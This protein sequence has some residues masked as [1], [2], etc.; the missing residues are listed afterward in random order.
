MTYIHRHVHWVQPKKSDKIHTK[1]NKRQKQ[2]RD[3]PKTIG[4]NWNINSRKT[5]VTKHRITKI[6]AKNDVHCSCARNDGG[7][8]DGGDDDGGISNSSKRMALQCKRERQKKIIYNINVSDYH[9]LK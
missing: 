6:P 4:Q 2:K 7:G 1:W 3:W 5:A 9:Y 8:G